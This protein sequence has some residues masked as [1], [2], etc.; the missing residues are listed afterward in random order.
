MSL[1]SSP[2][3]VQFF[4]CAVYV[5][6]VVAKVEVVVELGMEAALTVAEGAVLAMMMVEDG[7]VEEGIGVVVVVE[8]EIGVVGMIKKD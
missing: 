7:L 2:L 4:S 3:L 1:L 8:E 5:A 6:A